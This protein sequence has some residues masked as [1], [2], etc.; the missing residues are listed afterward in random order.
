VPPVARTPRRRRADASGFT[1]D[2]LTRAGTRILVAMA[3]AARR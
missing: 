2:E 1:L 3:T